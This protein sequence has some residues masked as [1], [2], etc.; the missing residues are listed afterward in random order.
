[1]HRNLLALLLLAA[2]GGSAR[3]EGPAALEDRF[4]VTGSGGPLILDGGL[5]L[6]HPAGLDTGLSTGVGVGAMV[7]ARGDAAA[8]ASLAR[9]VRVGARLSWSTA[10]ESST[11]WTVTQSD[12]KLR[13][14]AEL[15]HVAGRGTFGLRVG[16][17]P[18]FV[19]ETRLR[20]QGVRA[21]L[22]GSYLEQ[23]TWATLPAADVEAMVGLHVLGPWLLV[24]SGG[25]SWSLSGGQIKTGWTALVGTG[26]QR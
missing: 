1:M 23:T 16:L 18:T 25:P 26:W 15:R 12:L 10:T 24:L 17:G 2:A 21:M 19:H 7:G 22:T 14:A 13:A 3:A 9:L 20:N 6:G 4:P 8:G 11:T 5:V